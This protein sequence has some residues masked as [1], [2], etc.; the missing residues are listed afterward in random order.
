M[1]A[2]ELAA[3]QIALGSSAR[4]DVPLV[5]GEEEPAAD[6][7]DWLYRMLK[8]L[9]RAVTDGHLDDADCN[10]LRGLDPKSPGSRHR[11]WLLRLLTLCR[12]HAHEAGAGNFDEVLETLQSYEA[13]PGL[14]VRLA[15]QSLRVAHGW[16]S[17]DGAAD[18]VYRA[19]LEGVR[20]LALRP[21]APNTEIERSLRATLDCATHR[22][23]ALPV[24]AALAQL[25][26]MG[27]APR[28]LGLYGWVDSPFRGEPGFS[29][30]RAV[31]AP[32]PAQAKAV[33][34]LKDRY[35]AHSE[36]G[37]A[38]ADAWDMGL[39]SA[40]VRRAVELLEAV[41]AGAH[42]GEALGR[43][44]ESCFPRYADVLKLRGGDPAA[45][46]GGY[47]ADD[48][49]PLRRTCDGLAALRD[50]GADLPRF[51]ARTGLDPAAIPASEASELDALAEV[52]GVVADLHL[53]EAV[54][55]TVQGGSAV[56]AQAL[57]S[58]AGLGEVPEL[59][60]VRTPVPGTPLTTRVM[61]SLPRAPEPGAAADRAVL[62]DPATASLLDGLGDA[63]DPVQFGWQ[64]GAVTVTL[65][66]LGLQPGDLAAVDDTALLA[67]VAESA[68]PP[69]PPGA[70]PESAMPPGVAA[71]R[72]VVAVLARCT[73]PAA[74]AGADDAAADD[75]AL[76]ARYER[77]HSAASALQRDLAAAAAAAGDDAALRGRALRWGVA[78]SFGAAADTLAAGLA[79]CPSVAE[80]LDP[81]PQRRADPGDALRRLAAVARR[82]SAAVVVPV[83]VAPEPGPQPDPAPG[84]DEWRD[85]FARVRPALAQFHETLGDRISATRADG[86]GPAWTGR[87]VPGSADLPGAARELAV[88]YALDGSDPGADVLGVVDQWQETL[89][90]RWSPDGTVDADVSATA[91]FGFNSPGARAQQAILLAVPPSPDAELDIPLLRRILAQTRLLVRARAVRGR[92]LGRLGALLPSAYLPA[93][94][95]HG[96]VL[97]DSVWQPPTKTAGLHV[98][99]EQSAP[100]G[101]VDAALQARTADPLWMMTRQWELGEH[102]GENATSPVWARARVKAT[103][104]SAP[105]ER[106][107]ADPAAVPGSAALEA[108]GAD[109]PAAGGGA[110]PFDPS[111]FGHTTA[112][113][114]GGADFVA[115]RH[116]GGESDWWSVD[117]EGT[118]RATGAARTMAGLPGRMRYPGAPAPGWCTLE[119]PGDS[120]MGHLP[121]T[122]HV[123]S[124]FFLDVLAG[125]S[126]DWYLM[127]L[128]APPGRVLS[129]GRVTVVDAFGDPWVL[130]TDHW[131]PAQR[132]SAFRTTGLGPAD[133]LLWPADPPPLSG[134]LLERVV[135]GVDEDANL[136]WVV[137]DVVAGGPPLPDAPDP[138][139]GARGAGNSAPEV[140]YEVR[141]DAPPRW[142]PYPAA[143]DPE[144]RRYRQGRLATSRPPGTTDPPAG[145]SRILPADVVHA[146][147]P[148]A[149]PARGLVVERRWV[150][151]RAADGAPVVWQQRTRGVP[152]AP[153][154]LRLPFDVVTPAQ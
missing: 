26:T 144:P 101:D 134:P 121:D 108:A 115:R 35:A 136:L 106:P 36:S 124:L 118:F 20:G 17:D 15:A 153:P 67:A 141:G 143:D 13:A 80:V 68:P 18:E 48:A 1:P 33:A 46:G 92:D 102:Q 78:G 137:E 41:A 82:D 76:R 126:T 27:P 12:E 22:L 119:E 90:G 77:L 38:P 110:D 61:L 95:D 63:A 79:R 23:D 55:D 142:H 131:G 99:L 6:P 123:G 71:V 65:A 11:V 116:A 146:I 39:D 107:F 49:A 60:S 45:G 130:P 133:L 37:Q 14:L 54:H 57:D 113:R 34:I 81:D 69:Q 103:P 19:A 28:V 40:A 42:P 8:D 2:E 53:L 70:E 73:P 132:W 91:A 151:A 4:V 5:A 111:G 94:A 145:S 3:P 85:L 148:A 112:V 21:I 125:H 50:W 87:A 58:L 93:D 86:W 104:L 44:V 10:E 30:D 56:V 109:W 66:D 16:A 135:L 150:L 89:P 154:A 43:R 122:A 24:A 59:R 25:D 149:V 105:E 9:K 7:P 120:V 147:D 32:S 75:A 114:G 128:A 74:R 140:R 64:R 83:L 97:D 129:L 84:A 152:T 98:R 31:L 47:P 117:A 139:G 100:E 62:A 96:I 127:P 138:A 51:A 88:F 29:K 72:E 52:A